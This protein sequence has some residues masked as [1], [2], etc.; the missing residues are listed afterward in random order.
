MA[1]HTT[2]SVTLYLQRENGAL[3]AP[4][5]L[6]FRKQMEEYFK[7]CQKL[8]DLIAN[9]D[10]KRRDIEEIVEFYNRQCIQ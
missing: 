9:K 7:D 5:T 2:I 4:N 10:F 6:G 3:I 8:A 1:G